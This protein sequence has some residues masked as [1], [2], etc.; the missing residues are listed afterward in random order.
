MNL[1]PLKCNVCERQIGWI[2]SMTT[3]EDLYC[4]KDCASIK[5]EQ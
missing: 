1:I 3:T 5:D 4:S 2:D